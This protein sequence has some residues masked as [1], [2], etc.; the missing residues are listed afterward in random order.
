MLEIKLPAKSLRSAPWRRVRQAKPRLCKKSRLK[1][2]RSPRNALPSRATA[3]PGIRTIQLAKFRGYN[4]GAKCGQLSTADHTFHHTLRRLLHL[5]AFTR[6]PQY[7]QHAVAATPIAGRHSH[8]AHITRSAHRQGL[9]P[10][11]IWPSQTSFAGQT[12]RIC[13]ICSIVTRLLHE[14]LQN[15][16]CAEVAVDGKSD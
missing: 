2:K 14:K 13:A 8:T 11:R 3:T 12:R 1:A 4:A 16:K 6:A 7:V 10:L 9:S 5:R 15:R